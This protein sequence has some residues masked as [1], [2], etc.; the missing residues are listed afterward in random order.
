M[1]FIQQNIHLE[2]FNHDDIEYGPVLGKG[3]EGVVQRCKVTYNELPVE[4]AVKTV[5]NNSDDALTITL[6]EIEL[7]WYVCAAVVEFKLIM[8][9]VNNRLT[10][11]ER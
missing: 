9:L 6:D 11:P 10:C 8:G 5:L 1:L 2:V 4:A 3:G 7:L